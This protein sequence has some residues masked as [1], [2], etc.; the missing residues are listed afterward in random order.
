MTQRKKPGRYK[1]RKRKVFASRLP[2]RSPELNKLLMDRCMWGRCLECG[3]PRR[4]SYCE[5][6]R[7]RFPIITDVAGP[8]KAWQY[9][10]IQIRPAYDVPAFKAVRVGVFERAGQHEQWLG[11]A[12]TFQQAKQFCLNTLRR[13]GGYYI[14]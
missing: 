10:V 13:A 2:L 5:S 4:A 12:D 8:F 3:Q 1:R 9:R 14:P 6:C 7:A 11:C